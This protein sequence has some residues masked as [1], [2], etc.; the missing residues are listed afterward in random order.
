MAN[1][2]IKGLD[3]PI[4]EWLP[5]VGAFSSDWWV[6]ANKFLRHD[7]EQSRY[8]YAFAPNNNLYKIDA[9]TG[10]NIKVSD[11][12]NVSGVYG[13]CYMQS[14]GFKGRVLS[15]TSNTFTSALRD[16]TKF[17]GKKVKIISGTGAGQ[18]RI[19]KSITTNV[20]VRGSVTTAY[21]AGLIDSNKT[22][23][24]NQWRGYQ[25][26]IW[27]NGN[28]FI[29]S[30]VYNWDTGLSWENANLMSNSYDLMSTGG[31][32]VAWGTTTGQI[33][34]IESQTAVI[35]SNWDV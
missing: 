33:Y 9:E 3:Q 12:H 4:S 1:K 18:Q 29:N 32:S 15:S 27:G 17:I 34:Q 14:K 11:L 22:W 6:T 16:N 30:V 26:I 10:S 25:S 23:A 19:I 5:Q 35:D 7:P 13:V 28:T 21:G 8:F 2:F 20:H 31:S 24:V